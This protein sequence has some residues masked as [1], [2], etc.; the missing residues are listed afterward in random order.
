MGSLSAM[1]GTMTTVL[2]ELRDLVLRHALA[3]TTVTAV[4]GLTLYRSGTVTMPMPVVYEPMLCVIVQG[5]KRVTLGD[6][7]CHYDAAHSLVASLDLPVVGVICEAS[8]ETPYLSLSLRLDRMELAA[9]LLQM[10]AATAPM[11]DFSGL[12]V[13]PLSPQLV[14]ACQRLVELLDAPAD[15]P[16]LAPLLRRELL[17]RLLTGPHGPMLRQIARGEGRLGQVQ[18]AIAWIREH[19]ARP[20]SVEA[21]AA[22]VALSTSSLHRH[23]KAATRLSPLQYQ[24]QLRLQAARERLMSESADAAEVAYAVGYESPSQFSREFRRLFGHPP[25]QAARRWRLEAAG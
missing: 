1:V 9:L 20:M 7:V 6:T 14:G 11:Q 3:E 18:Q 25:A 2:P 23:F 22:Q 16:I 13:T 24:K 12:E 10:P 5:R 15:I 19:Y 8:P 17:Y 4:P 21:L